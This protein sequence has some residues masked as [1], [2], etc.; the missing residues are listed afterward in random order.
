MRRRS[1]ADRWLVPSRARSLHA[2]GLLLPAAV[3]IMLVVPAG[4]SAGQ[5]ASG[6]PSAVAE[7]RAAAAK[8]FARRRHERVRTPIRPTSRTLKV[9]LGSDPDP[10]TRT[11]SIQTPPLKSTQILIVELGGDLERTDSA[12]FPANQI[13]LVTHVTRLGQVSLEVCLDPSQPSSVSPGRYV[14][15]ITLGGSG[16]APTAF[17]V[18]VTV[19]AGECRA[20][21]FIL[22]GTIFGLIAKMLIDI[23]KAPPTVS[24]ASL[25]DYLGQGVFLMALLTAAVGGVV[26]YLA[27]YE[28]N[29][30]WG[31]SFDEI[32]IFVAG[33]VLQTTGT[34]L[35]DLVQPYVPH[36]PGNASRP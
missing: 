12:T 35:T 15:A 26:N 13:S 9:Q 2:V 16:I 20:I 10:Q 6:C 1:Q 8:R 21:L 23:A 30:T 14:G 11:F 27:L 4:V 24:R 25:K 18:E 19:Q 31:S 36:L 5:R 29:P 28:P 34:T 32:K 17:P 7:T 3:S 22:L 33:V